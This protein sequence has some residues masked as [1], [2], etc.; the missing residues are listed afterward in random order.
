MFTVGKTW[1][2]PERLLTDTMDKDTMD[3]QMVHIQW[4]TTQ[5]LKGM[6]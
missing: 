1:K 2:Q 4:N 6:K 3:M 5:P